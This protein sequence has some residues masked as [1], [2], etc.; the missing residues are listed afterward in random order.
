VAES[1]VVE[2][3]SPLRITFRGFRRGARHERSSAMPRPTSSHSS[4]YPRGIGAVYPGA[5]RR[6]AEAR[7]AMLSVVP[8]H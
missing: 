3:G 8:A 5:R 7:T 6:R 2:G 1:H 4:T